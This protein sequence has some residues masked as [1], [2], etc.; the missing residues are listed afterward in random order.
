[1]EPISA[2]W[3]AI[4][5]LFIGTAMLSLSSKLR[6]RLVRL[7]SGPGLTRKLKQVKAV[8]LLSLAMA[9]F[10][11]LT[12]LLTCVTRVSDLSL[13]C[14]P[15]LGTYC[16]VLAVVMRRFFACFNRSHSVSLRRSTYRRGIFC[17]S[18][19]LPKFFQ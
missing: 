11:L 18:Q 5:L 8:G 19:D 7:H 10:V 3:R 6:Q 13:L 1:M 15:I 17:F 9:G 12:F 14:L 16:V 2:A 4:M